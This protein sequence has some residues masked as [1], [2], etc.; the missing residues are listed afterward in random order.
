MKADPKL[1][2]W[3]NHT[4]RPAVVLIDERKNDAPKTDRGWAELAESIQAMKPDTITCLDSSGAVLRA[5]S[6]ESFFP[7]D[8]A[9]SASNETEL[10]T[11]ARLVA[12]AYKSASLQFNPLLEKNM[13]FSTNLATRLARTE[14]ELDRAR[15]T[16]A[17][18]QLEIAELKAEPVPQ[19]TDDVGGGIVAGLIQAHMQAE[20]QQQEPAKVNGKGKKS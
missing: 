20:Q 11:L 10:E 7:E 12:D 14:Q 13:E 5:R 18:L 15:A 9:P 3:L 4:P 2:K 19:A 16:I 17:K 6:F 1:R 8:A